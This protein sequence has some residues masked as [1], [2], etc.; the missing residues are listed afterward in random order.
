MNIYVS[1]VTDI[2]IHSASFESEHYWVKKIRVTTLSTL[3]SLALE[4]GVH[5]LAKVSKSGDSAPP[6]KLHC[7]DASG[8]LGQLSEAA[9][10]G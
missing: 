6:R 10:S 5:V 7:G 1:S 8:K 2:R 4:E 9:C 3:N